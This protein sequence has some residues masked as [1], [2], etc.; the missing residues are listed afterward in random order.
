[1]ALSLEVIMRTCDS[2]QVHKDWRVRYCDKPK[3]DIIRVCLN[4]LIA[5]CKNSGLEIKLTVIDDNST[6]ETK[7]F[8]YN[9]LRDSGFE[10]ELINVSGGYNNSALIQYERCRDSSY[11]LVYSAEDDYLHF[12]TAI[13]EMVDS[14][15]IFLERLEGKPVVIYPFDNP[16]EYSNSPSQCHL[17]LGSGRHWRTGLYTTQVLMTSPELFKKFWPLFE[18]IATKYNGDYL[19]PREEHYEESNTIWNIWANGHAVRFNPVPS[20]ALHLQFPENKDPFIDWEK[21]WESYE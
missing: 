13:K 2:N 17:V 10:Y 1:M 12:P 8:L 16:E 21:L 11:D 15:G 14:Y 19:R 18:L 20:L 4:S 9:S 3:Q 6:Q 5:S 7:A